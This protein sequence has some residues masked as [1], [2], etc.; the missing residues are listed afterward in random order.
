M[1]VGVDPQQARRVGVQVDPPGA[2]A[3]GGQAAANAG[4]VASRV[5]GLV[6]RHVARSP[7]ARRSP[8]VRPASRSAA[9]A[10]SSSTAPLRST[11]PGRRWLCASTAP[12]ASLQRQGAE[13]HARFGRR[14]TPP[15]ARRGGPRRVRRRSTARSPAP[16]PPRCSARPGRG[17]APC[18]AVVV[19]ELAQPLQ[20]RRVRL[21]AAERADVEGARCSA[22]DPAPGRRASGRAS[23]SPR[24]CARPARS[25][26]IASSGQSVLMV[27]SGNRSSVA[28]DAARIDHRDGAA[29]AARPTA[30][31]PGRYAPRRPRPAAAADCGRAGTS[32]RRPVSTVPLSSRPAR[33]AAASASSAGASG[34]GQQASARRPAACVATTTGRFAAR[35]A[36]SAASSSGVT[37][38]SPRTLS[39]CRRR[40]GRLP[41]RVRW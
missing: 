30:P 32:R 25:A 8:S 12:S 10:V 27:T 18:D 11:R 9:S 17:C 19:A 1:R 16:S 2:G 3:A 15:A 13:D 4:A 28:K 24:P 5:G 31:A 21:P 41:R 20:P 38:A 26:S 6:L 22:P 29:R 37:T 7:A 36:V 14:S 33:V 23:A 39:P 34:D 40:P 35:A